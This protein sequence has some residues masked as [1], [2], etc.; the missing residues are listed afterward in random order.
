MT[1]NNEKLI[2]RRSL[3]AGVGVAAAGMSVAA[4]TA[5]AAES[6]FQPARHSEDQWMDKLPGTHRTWID[7]SYPTG[8]LEAL[9]FANNILN[10]NAK[11]YGGD[12]SDYAMVICWRHYAAP[13]AFGDEVWSEYGE[14]LSNTMPMMDPKSGGAFHVNPANIAGRP[15]LDNSGNTIDETLFRGVK[16]AICDAATRWYAEVVAEAS[17]GSAGNIYQE[18]VASAIPNSRFVSAGVIA[19]TRAQE[20][21]YSL[22]YAG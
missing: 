10:A 17:G 15:D 12:D 13:F 7:T 1:D 11:A 18:F 3:L 4:A 5:N 16:I 19:T 14:H 21:G 20:Y 9:H 22:L 6:G 2:Q 8:G